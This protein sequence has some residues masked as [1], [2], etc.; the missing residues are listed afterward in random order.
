MT[1]FET[2]QEALEQEQTFVSNLTRTMSLTLDTFY[3]SLSTCGVS[4]M[5]G[6]GFAQLLKKIL[7]CVTEYE[8]DYKPV[9]EKMRQERLAEQAAGPKP[10]D[11]VEDDGVP[12]NLGR[13]LQVGTVFE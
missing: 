4:A 8:R 2:F 12:V 6:V 11:N 5:T 3:E 13:D 7:D 1:D 9:Y 10:A